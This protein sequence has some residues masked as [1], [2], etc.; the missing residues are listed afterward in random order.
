MLEAFAKSVIFVILLALGG[1]FFMLFR[2]KGWF[3]PQKMAGDGASP[4]DLRVTERLSIGGRHYIAVVRC[5]GQ[6]FLIGISPTSITALG[7][8]RPRSREGAYREKN[9]N[10]AHF[11]KNLSAKDGDMAVEKMFYR[12]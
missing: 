9:R 7:A 12:R 6:E 5:N 2:K 11:E 4:S 3:F 10:F 1:Y 8:L